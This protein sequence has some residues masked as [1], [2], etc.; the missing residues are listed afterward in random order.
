M[1]LL[2]RCTAGLLVLTVTA[3]AATPNLGS[4]R[5]YALDD[6]AALRFKAVLVAGDRATPAFDHATDAMRE[7]LLERRVAAA[8]IQ[9]LSADREVV[10]R[11]GVRSATLDHVLSAIGGLRPEPG[12]GC[13]VFVTSHGGFGRGLVLTPSRD[14][15]TPAALDAALAGGCGNA[16]TVAVL[17]GCFSGGFAK[18]PMARANRIVLTAA[19]EDRPSFGCGAGFHYTVYDRCLLGAMDTANTWRAAYGMIR[20]CVTSR[21][22]ELGFRPSEPRAWFGAAVNGMPVPRP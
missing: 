9:Q 5:P 21:E 19:R 10:T 4:V 13:L 1:R 17:S 16:P 20:D 8:D 7:R 15:L 14:Y 6:L 3:C 12:Q 18:A 2:T 22:R 11:E